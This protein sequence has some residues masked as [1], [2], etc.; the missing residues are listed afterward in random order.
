[1]EEVLRDRYGNMLG[2]I[3]DNGREM[4]VR[5]KFGNKCGTYEKSTNTTRDRHGNKVGTGNLLVALLPISL[6]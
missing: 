5:D 2:K 3:E 4:I 6:I 1:M